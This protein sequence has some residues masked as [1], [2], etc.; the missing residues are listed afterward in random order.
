METVL[1]NFARQLSWQP[2]ITHEMHLVRAP[3]VILCGMGGSRLAGD[4]VRS[5]LPTR[6]IRIHADFGFPPIVGNDTLFVISSYSGTTEETLD[7]FHAIREKKGHIAIVTGGGTLLREA[8]EGGIPFIEIPEKGIPPRLAVGYGVRALL[9]FM[10]EDVA[11]AKMA[12]TALP[13][14]LPEEGE[15]L[16]ERLKGSLPLIY[17]SRRMGGLAYY[18]KVVLNETAKTHAFANVFPEAGHNEIEGF[19]SAKGG[20]VAC[21]TLTDAEDD[22][23]I[24]M[25]LALFTRTCREKDIV[26]IPL[27]L[28][29][30]NV[31]ERI[32]RSVMLVN[33]TALHLAKLHRIDPSRTTLIDQ[34]KRELRG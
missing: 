3:R 19:E 9:T 17:A 24:R 5:A 4:L 26:A 10:G 21:V 28:S 12:S 15:A 6:D 29:G 1:K 30:N 32:F 7:A 11:S 8:R 34:W 25:R 16:A 2:N 31:W 23:R 14:T 33:W 20:R 13:D 22:E 27:S 18:W